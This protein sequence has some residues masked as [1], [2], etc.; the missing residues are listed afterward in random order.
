[1]FIFLSAMPHS[2]PNQNDCYISVFLFFQFFVY[3]H[4]RMTYWLI[5]QYGQILKEITV[6]KDISMLLSILP[7]RQGYP[8]ECSLN[9]K[10]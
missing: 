9:G 2:D 10:L 3:N 4:I 5:L 7:S 1:M 8:V 6:L